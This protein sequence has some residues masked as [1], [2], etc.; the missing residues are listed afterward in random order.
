MWRVVVPALVLGVVGGILGS[1]SA[2]VHMADVTV[3]GL[4]GVACGLLVG[5]STYGRTRTTA[6]GVYLVVGSIVTWLILA[7]ILPT[8]IGGSI[9]LDVAVVRVIAIGTTVC[10]LIGCVAGIRML[11]KRE[12]A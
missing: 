1:K 11:R 5:A 6:W 10:C 3:G 7:V 12:R 8:L 9:G 2:V 4:A